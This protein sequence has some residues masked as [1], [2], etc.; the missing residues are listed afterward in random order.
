MPVAA[1]R[2]HFFSELKIDNRVGDERNQRLDLRQLDQLSAPGAFALAH[3]HHQRE[4]AM[5]SADRIAQRVAE[6]VTLPV[7]VVVTRQSRHSRHRL[8]CVA[9]AARVAFGTVA[10][11]R[12]HRDHDEPRIDRAHRFVAEPEPIHHAGTEILDQDVGDL[13]QPFQ[14]FDSARA[15][16]IERDAP[17]AAIGGIEDR[18]ALDRLHLRRRHRERTAPPVEVMRVLDL[19]HVGAHL[20]EHLADQRPRPSHR[21]VEHANLAV[22]D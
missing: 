5:Q 1:R 14:D 12:R 11:E 9:V 15:R 18:G 3:R 17:L 4:H 13:D 19:D 2:R 16:E 6:R 7:A 22:K 10:P 21:D 20:G 8:D